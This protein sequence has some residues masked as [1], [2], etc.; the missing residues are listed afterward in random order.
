M[1]KI[2]LVFF[3][4]GAWGC[5]TVFMWSIA[6]QN[7]QVVDEI[8]MALP[9]PLHDVS[10]AFSV[11]NVRLIMRYQASEVNRLFFDGWGM[12]QIV[13]A[14]IVLLIVSKMERRFLRVAAM[15]LLGV[16]LILQFYVVPETIRLGRI[17]DFLPRSPSPP[18]A[19]L[20]WRLHHIYTGLDMAKFITILGLSTT[21]FL[22]REY[23]SSDTT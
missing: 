10:A 13:V 9:G 12:A 4:L 8:L 1:K 18:E 22:R 14:V 21:I 15:L 5:G 3:L 20:F 6:M 17:I 16:C 7:F 11:E 2:S 19:I 23:W